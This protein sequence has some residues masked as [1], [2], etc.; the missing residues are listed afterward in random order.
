MNNPI[1]SI[2]IPAYNDEKYIMRCLESIESQSYKE[3][4][5]LLVLDGSTDKTK[6]LSLNFVGRVNN[7]HIIEQ[8]NAGSGRARNNGIEHSKGEYVVFVDA[9]DWLEPDALSILMEIEND[10]NAD[11]IV[12]NAIV[13]EKKDDAEENKRYVGHAEDSFVEGSTEVSKKYFDLDVDA[14]SHSPWG[15][16]FKAS[17]IRENN[18]RFPDLRRSQ[19]IVFNNTYARYINSIYVSKQYIYNFWNTIYTSK[20]YKDSKNRRN[21][22]RF[23]EAEKNHLGTMSRVVGSFYE[24]MEIRG[25]YLTEEDYQMRNDSYLVG[26]YNNIAANAKR[27][28]NNVKYALNTYN[29]D[30]FFQRAIAKPKNVMFVYRVMAFLLKNRWYSLTAYYVLLCE[31]LNVIL[32]EIRK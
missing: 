18:V 16:L 26:I 25:Y 1:V 6:E 27:N 24:T 15:K 23:I 31:R 14:S 17:I 9:D 21:S 32:K 7:L 5:V 11:Y 13:V 2:V 29:K 19:D 28:I 20:V 8:E 30:T 12:A 3:Y 4:E 22:P 10:T